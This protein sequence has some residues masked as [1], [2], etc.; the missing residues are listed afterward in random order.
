MPILQNRVGAFLLILPDID[1]I[2][3]F[4]SIVPP[5]AECA[6]ASRIWCLISLVFQRLQFCQWLNAFDCTM[7]RQT[8]MA[9]RERLS[10][11]G[12]ARVHRV[13]RLLLFAI[14][15]FFHQTGL[16]RLLQLR[17][18]PASAYQGYTFSQFFTTKKLWLSL[19][20]E[21]RGTEDYRN[22]LM[23]DNE[24]YLEASQQLL[25]RGHYSEYI[26]KYAHYGKC[27]ATMLWLPG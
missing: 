24:E 5:S 22:P 4:R 27:S 11:I 6:L 10:F 14:T 16:A 21:S 7:C 23:W 19:G 25:Y 17:F 8:K 18:W 13:Q 3:S 26:L 1:K 2:L 15:F 9:E 20:T 12:F